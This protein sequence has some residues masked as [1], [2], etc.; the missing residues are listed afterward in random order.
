MDQQKAEKLIEKYLTGTCSQEEK[1]LVERFYMKEAE[2]RGFDGFVDWEKEKKTSWEKIEAETSRKHHH[3]I[4][5]FW[6]RVA[7]AAS[8]ILILFAGLY[9]YSQ[10]QPD[11]SDYTAV[12]KTDIAP[13]SNKAVL[14][15]D[16]GTKISLDDASTGEVARQSG[17]RVTKTADG[18]LIYDASARPAELLGAKGSPA[19]NTITTPR[20]GQYEVILPDGTKVWLNAAS[21]L[22]YPAWF[23][24]AER[25]VELRGEAYFEVAH[26]DA[27]PFRV[28]AAGQIVEVLGTHFNINSY[29]DEPAVKT[30]LLEGSVKV[31]SLNT[32]S[33]VFLKP[34]EQ[35]ALAGH[36]LAVAAVDAGN[37]VAWKNGLFRFHN[38]DVKSVMRQYSRWYDVEVEF[39]GEVPSI[40][41]WGEVYRTVDASKAL[42]I[43]SYF[44]LKY[45]I[46]QKNDKQKKIIISQ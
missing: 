11:Q 9:F 14:T 21:S 29:S 30:T 39:A 16:D 2:K 1:A 43:L 3:G 36:K 35:S 31:S 8:I 23:T 4:K 18:K 6:P 40:R 20:G 15:L 19:Y 27:M 34:G 22:K 41:L 45:E 13:G 17:I 24:G 25:R 46:V 28:A 38:S 5:K 7:A 44:N 37:A 42:E 10:K 12:I 32:G 26:N 33:A